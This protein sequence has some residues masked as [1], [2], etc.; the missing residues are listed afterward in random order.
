MWE[1]IRG[2]SPG[3]KVATARRRPVDPPLRLILMDLLVT[4]CGFVLM[5]AA[6]II[7]VQSL[8]LN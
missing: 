7:A 6:V 1:S 8:S 5:V 4:S 2:T 3:R